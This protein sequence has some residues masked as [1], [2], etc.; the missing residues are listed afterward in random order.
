M[1][2]EEN[3]EQKLL[4]ARLTDKIKESKTKNIKRKKLYIFWRI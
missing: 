4:I 1:K 3:L 2:G